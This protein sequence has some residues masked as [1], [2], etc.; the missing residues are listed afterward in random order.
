M[1]TFGKLK[2]MSSLNANHR[3]GVAR[4]IGTSR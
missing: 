4:F 2:D 1:Y 3:D